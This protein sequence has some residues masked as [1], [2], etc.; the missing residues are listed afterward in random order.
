MQLKWAITVR[1]INTFFHS[2]D[3]LLFLVVLSSE[4]KI[5]S[6]ITRFRGE[7]REEEKKIEFFLL[8]MFYQQFMIFDSVMLFL[9]NDF[10]FLRNRKGVIRVQAIKH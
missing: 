4:Q 9:W 5:W 6:K 7:R 1:D 3:S 2:V 8:L 10:V